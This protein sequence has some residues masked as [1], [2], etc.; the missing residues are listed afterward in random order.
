MK[1]N[2]RPPGVTPTPSKA[3]SAEP[4]RAGQAFQLGGPGS[5]KVLATVQS[6]FSAGDLDQPEK[7]DQ[8]VRES[9]A[10]IVAEQPVSGALPEE[11]RATLADFMAADPILHQKMLSYLRKTLT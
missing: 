2:P 1:I 11:G 10:A 4:A 3:E 5:E 7:A 8:A 6:R 9:F